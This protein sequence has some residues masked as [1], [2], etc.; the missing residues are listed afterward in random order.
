MITRSSERLQR[1]RGADLL[2]WTAVASLAGC[3][4][5]SPTRPA[6]GEPDVWVSDLQY[7]VHVF[8]S[9]LGHARQMAFAPNGDL[10]VNNGSV[11]VVFDDDGS[12]SSSDGYSRIDSKSK[13]CMRSIGNVSCGLSN[14]APYRPPSTHF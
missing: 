9:E 14:I 3:G 1:A 7:C 2:W 4:S 8:A 5:S 6:C 12:G 10:F 11:M 13:T